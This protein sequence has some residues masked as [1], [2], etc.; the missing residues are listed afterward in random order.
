[1]NRV[2]R[3]NAA[4]L[5]PFSI[6]AILLTAVVLQTD[7][8]E[9][10]LRTN[11]WHTP[12]ADTIMPLVT[13]LGDGVFVGIVVLLLSLYKLKSG[14]ALLIASLVNSLSTQVLKR[15]IFQHFRPAH[16]LEHHPDFLAIPGVDLAYQFS[17]PSGHTSAA[18]CLY[19]ALALL[20]RSASAKV[21]MLLLAV[22]VGASRIYLNL[23][24]LEDVVAGAVHG[25][26][27]AILSFG[28]AYSWWGGPN[29]ISKYKWLDFSI[30]K[31]AK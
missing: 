15:E 13:F 7:Q 20:F 1:M 29:E 11:Q 25:V 27:W 17:F 6:L 24:F 18:F 10:H 31:N 22:A 26:F 16:Y 2:V 23:H 28:M 21:L 3:E 9:L 19:F 14:L 30:F 5:A 12:L 4:F 8:L